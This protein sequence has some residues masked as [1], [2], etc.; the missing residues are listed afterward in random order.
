[1]R[2]LLSLNMHIY[3][4]KMLYGICFNKLSILSTQILYIYTDHLF[5]LT[6]ALEEKHWK[7]RW[8][9]NSASGIYRH[10][11]DECCNMKN[12]SVYRR[13]LKVLLLATDRKLHIL[14]VLHMTKKA[15]IHV[16]FSLF[17]KCYMLSFFPLFFLSPHIVKKR[18]NQSTAC[19]TH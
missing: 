10:G 6:S 15:K 4:L 3:I 13:S 1:M 11:I 9:K 5:Q 18:K 2:K 19:L 8:N 12:T 7:I 17:P 14:L 16:A